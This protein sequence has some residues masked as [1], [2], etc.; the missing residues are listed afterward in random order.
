M[1][2]A[3]Y[4]EIKVALEKAVKY[5]I[6]DMGVER[7]KETSFFGSNEIRGREVKQAA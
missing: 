5:A 6:E 7:F 4:A 3:R 1:T 2:D